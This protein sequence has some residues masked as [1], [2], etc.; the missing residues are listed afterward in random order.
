[1]NKISRRQ[2]LA[3]SAIAAMYSYSGHAFSASERTPAGNS[4]SLPWRN[5]SGSVVGYPQGR[6]SPSTENELSSYLKSTSGSIRP[7]GSGHSF[8]PLVPTNGH[9]IVADQFDGLISHDPKEMTATFGAGTRLANMGAALQNI[10]QAFFNMPDIDRQTLAGATATATHGTGINFQCL[11]GY[12]THL[13]LITP[14]GEQIDIDE[15]SDPALFKAACVS[16]GALGVITQITLRNRSPYRLKQKSWIENTEDILANFDRHAA[17]HRHFEIMPMTHSDY[18]FVLSTDETDEPINNPPPSPEEEAAMGSAMR[19]WME[20]SP[21]DRRPL[22]NGLAEQV[23]PSEKV[24]ESYN[25]LANVRS[26]R[27]NEMEYAVP[28]EV[29]AECLREILRTISDKKIDVVFPLEYRYVSRD[30]TLLSM[31]SGH[32]DHAAISVHRIASEDYRPYFDLI[33]PIFWKYGGRPHW[34]KIHTLHEPELAKLY[35]GFN[36]F[37]SIRKQLD[38]SG[39]ML[40]DHLRKLFG[41]S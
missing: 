35:P 18:S 37:Q 21:E 3:T 30:D 13:R 2:F 41:E 24:D 14:Q 26:N 6:I 7:V 23:Q 11:S 25:I 33:E 8:T 29:G 15:A 16:I 12:I 9:I 31:S 39:R 19:S 5:W 27:F 28:L 36:D 22:I 4:S 1:M 17:S 34:G 38:P 32:E 20:V 10:G 40:N